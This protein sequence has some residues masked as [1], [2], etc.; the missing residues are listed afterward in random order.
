MDSKNLN[1]EG[2][3]VFAKVRRG[4]YSFAFLCEILRA[5]CVSNPTLIKKPAGS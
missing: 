4:K 5:L 3:E 1:A 2:A